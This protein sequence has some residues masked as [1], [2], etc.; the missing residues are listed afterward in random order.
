MTIDDGVAYGEP[1]QN[2]DRVAALRRHRRPA[3]RHRD[4]EG[5]RAAITGAAFVGWDST[6]SFNADGR[7]IPA[8]AVAAFLSRHAAVRD[9]SISSASGS[10]TFDEP[11]ND[12]KFRINDLAV[13]EESVGQV[14]GTLALRGTDLSGEI[15]AASPRLAVTGTG[16]IALI[17]EGDSELSFRF[18]DSSLDPY[19]RLFVPKLSPSTTAVASGSI[20]VAGELAD[21]DQPAGRRH[22]RRARDAAVR[23]RGEERG[24][25]PARARSGPGHASSDLQLVGEDTRLRVAGTVGLAG[26]SHRAAGGRRRE[27]RHPAGVLP[28]RAR[29]GPRGA[30]RGGR[31]PAARSRCFRAARRSPTAASAISRCRTRSTPS[32]ARCRST[33]AASASTT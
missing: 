30:D 15:D 24:A 3:R 33:P 19:V 32:T 1:F 7:R 2:G 20:R 27:P 18:H 21:F 31:R 12:F 10:G 4:R 13:A 11:R 29:L 6:Y 17:A 9:R 8:D 22:R 28:R 25:D 26:R 23:L 16:R 5:R 14:T